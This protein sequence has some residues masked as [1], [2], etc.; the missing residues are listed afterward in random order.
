VCAIGAR[1]IQ[2]LHVLELTPYSEFARRKLRRRD[3]GDAGGESG[4]LGALRAPVAGTEFGADSS[5]SYVARAGTN[6]G[7]LRL[8][9]LRRTR[10]ARFKGFGGLRREVS[11]QTSRARG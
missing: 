1:P 6:A 11:G 4:R 10:S 3:C 5:A 7:E 9:V 8:G 2:A